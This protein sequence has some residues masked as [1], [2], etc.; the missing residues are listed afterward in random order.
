[1]VKV[2]LE[3]SPAAS[4]LDTIYLAVMGYDLDVWDITLSSFADVTFHGEVVL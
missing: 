2:A 1:M 4:P 3:T